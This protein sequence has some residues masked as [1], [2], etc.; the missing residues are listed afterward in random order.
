MV[1]SNLLFL[2]IFLPLNLIT[3]Y[4]AKGTRLKN[5]VLIAFS[6]IFYA[7]GEPLWIGLLILSTL[8][9]YVHAIYIEK[10]NNPKHKKYLLIS[11]I[12]LNLALLGIFKYSSFFIENINYILSTSITIKSIA[13]PIGISFYTFQTISYTVDVYNQKVKAQKDFSK[14]LMY[15]SL[16]PQLIAGPIV[17]YIDIEREID[18][19]QVNI[20]N[21]Y[22]GLNRFIIGLCKKILI[23]N[24]AGKFVV[25]YMGGDISSITV[26]ES[27][28]GILMFTVQIYFDFSGY[29]DMAIGL[30]KMF[31]FNYCENF[32]YPYISKSATEF[33]R[34]W[35]ISLGSFFRDYVYIPL[36]GNRKR[37]VLNLFIV[38]FLT[39]FWHGASWNFILWGLYFGTI[40]YIE[41]KVTLKILE[42]LPSIISHIYLLLV[43]MVGWVI[44]YFTNMSDGI[45]YL[46]IMFGLSSNV[47][48]T[49]ALGIVIANNIWWLILSLLACTPLPKLV[50]HKLSIN[51]DEKQKGYIHILSGVVNA[52]IL[53][54]LISCLVG[55]SYNPFLYYRF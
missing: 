15:V 10:S 1:F 51:K 42:K 38:W 44:F 33:W 34:R 26:V 8:I 17:R 48:N 24:I 18:N 25:T 40:I 9:D 53:I 4:L 3:Y 20:D 23:A 7:W 21:I 14:L 6:L 28:F 54:V 39:G 16:Y 19:R 29:S 47:L 35:H 36:G 50:Y 32:N 30:G 52:L 11:D 13:L 27:W 43:A 41:K 49:S 31:G 46:Q 45:Q 55:E 12:V 22:T 2:F 5:I 37:Q